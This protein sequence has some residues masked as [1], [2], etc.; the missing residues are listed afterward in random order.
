MPHK[1]HPAIVFMARCANEMAG[2]A[3][4]LSSAVAME[5]AKGGVLLTPKR[6]ELNLLSERALRQW[7]TRHQ[8]V[9]WF[10]GDRGKCKPIIL[11]CGFFCLTTYGSRHVI[12]AAWRADV[13]RLLFL[14]SSCIIP[15]IRRAA[16]SG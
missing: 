4:V 11:P 15:Q 13:R 5:T 16:D 12:E 10:C 14:G 1:V 2:S 7:M 6:Q 8:P 9:W 3:I